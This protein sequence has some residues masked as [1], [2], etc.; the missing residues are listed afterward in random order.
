[1]YNY[2]ITS[3]TLHSGTEFSQFHLD[4]SHAEE[5]YLTFKKGAIFLFITLALI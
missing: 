2:T 4:Q 5:Y 1:M 3:F